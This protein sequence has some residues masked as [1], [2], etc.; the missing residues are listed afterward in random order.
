MVGDHVRISTQSQIEVRAQGEIVVKSKKHKRALTGFSKEVYKV[1]AVV[2][3]ADGTVLYKLSG[4]HKRNWYLRNELLKVEVEGMIK[5]GENKREDLSFGQ[6]G[7]DLEA[8]L[9]GLAESRSSEASLRQEELENKHED[10]VVVSRNSRPKRN[11]KQ[12]E[13]GFFVD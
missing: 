13:R 9:Q 10:D 12:V 7:F 5:V 8:H 4:E 2:K 3:K 1:T 11:R 6:G